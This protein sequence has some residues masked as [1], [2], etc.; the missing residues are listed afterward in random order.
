M[1]KILSYTFCSF[2][3]TFVAFIIFGNI[4]AAMGDGG[5]YSIILAAILSLWVLVSVWGSIIVVKLDARKKD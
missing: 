3:L 1:K 2:L 5:D 4:L